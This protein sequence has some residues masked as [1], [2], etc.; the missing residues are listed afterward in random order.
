MWSH[1]KEKAKTNPQKVGCTN[2]CF[3][4]FF[5]CECLFISYKT[6]ITP[7]T[8][9]YTVFLLLLTVTQYPKSNN[10]TKLNLLTHLRRKLQYNATI[11]IAILNITY[12]STE[13]EVNAHFLVNFPMVLFLIHIYFSVSYLFLTLS[14]KPVIFGSVSDLLQSQRYTLVISTK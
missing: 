12:R 14:L 13:L 1:V 9:C 5:F 2:N 11:I 10:T 7:T 8:Y 3:F 6:T 4:F